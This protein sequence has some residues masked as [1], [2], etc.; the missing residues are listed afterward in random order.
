MYSSSLRTLQPTLWRT[1][2]VLANRLRLRIL[3]QLLRRPDQTVSMIAR[4]LHMPIPV[5]SQYLR[6]LNARGLL[7]ARRAGKYVYYR[8]IADK[9]VAGAVQLL[10][11]VQQTLVQEK[12]P[13]DVI[14]RLVTAFTHPR[15]IAIIRALR[16]GAATR[17]SLRIRT[18]MSGRALSRHLKKLADRRFLIVDSRTYRCA[19]PECPLAKTLI[20]LALGE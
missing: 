6:A 15:R 8:P 7:Q 18:R 19:R 16:Y 5:A 20:W 3:Q 9:S 13:V 14:F 12:Q 10:K 2:R 17:S 11:A 4:K 1:C